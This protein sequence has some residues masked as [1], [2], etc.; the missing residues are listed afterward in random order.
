M[1]RAEV[2]NRVL[3]LHMFTIGEYNRVDFGC[4]NMELKPVLTTGWFEVKPDRFY[5]VEDSSHRE[6][7]FSTS[8]KVHYG[9]RS[10]ERATIGDANSRWSVETL[11]INIEH[12]YDM[13][14]DEA[15]SIIS[16]DFDEYIKEKE[17][18][19]KEKS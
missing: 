17:E 19:E 14:L 11:P 3:A 7:E 13:T 16:V 1:K 10:G 6:E 5:I 15:K 12:V 2:I 18:K 4:G 8:V 9:I